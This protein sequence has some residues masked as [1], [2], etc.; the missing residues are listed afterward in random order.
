MKVAVLVGSL[1]ASL[2]AAVV[3]HRRNRH[4]AVV[5][6]REKVDADG[7]GTPDVYGRR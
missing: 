5:E 6:A 2:L 3:L 1:L 7:D 4:Y